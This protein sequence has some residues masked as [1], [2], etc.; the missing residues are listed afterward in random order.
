MLVGIMV[1]RLQITIV[2]VSVA[3]LVGII[4]L[5]RRRKL[6]E[7]YSFLWLV[8]GI[9]FLLLALFPSLVEIL[10]HLVGTVLPVNTLFFVG[11]ILIMMLCLYFS[12]RISNLTTQ[13]KNLSQAV[14]IL[15]AD[16]RPPEAV[17]QERTRKEQGSQNVTPTG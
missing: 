11:L 1:I 12:L 6:R 9:G 8:I 7:E 3:I 2:I 4:E 15:K 5:V 17:D 14:S 16:L 13:V 10:A